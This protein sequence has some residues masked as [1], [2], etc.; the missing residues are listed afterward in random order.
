MFQ[1]RHTRERSRFFSSFRACGRAKIGPKFPPAVW[2]PKLAPFHPK[3]FS[4]LPK[5]RTRLPPASLHA[6]RVGSSLSS[7]STPPSSHPPASS[8]LPP[9]TLGSTPPPSYHPPA[10]SLLPPLTHRSDASL[11]SPTGLLPPP[12]SYPSI[13]RLPPLTD[14]PP[15]TPAPLGGRT[16][17]EVGG[18]HGLGDAHG[19]GNAHG[20]SART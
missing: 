3:S 2:P 10:S 17:D 16:I 1:K 11:L 12:S 9:L 7:R 13:R 8:L 6:D 4:L 19:L 15:S 14:G 20:E 18:E 5:K